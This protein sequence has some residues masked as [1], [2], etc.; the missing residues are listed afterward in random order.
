MLH[1]VDLT[2]KPFNLNEQDITWVQETL[3]GLTLEDRK[4]VV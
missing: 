1:Q 3:E 4:S 2:K